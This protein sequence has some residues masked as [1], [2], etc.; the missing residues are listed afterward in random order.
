MIS[1]RFHQ[2]SGL[3]DNCEFDR[4]EKK[5]TLMDLRGFWEMIYYQVEDVD[6]KFEAL[7]KQKQ[8]NWIHL[9]TITPA[10][11]ST[12]NRKRSS[13]SQVTSKATASSGL[14]ALIAAKRK[15]VSK[16]DTSDIVVQESEETSE[17]PCSP[18]K[19]FDGGFFKISSPQLTQDSPSRLTRSAGLTTQCLTTIIAILNCFQDVSGQCGGPRC[20]R[21]PRGCLD[22]SPP[23]CLNSQGGLS[24]SGELYIGK[25]SLLFQHT[26]LIAETNV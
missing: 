16:D 22:W 1:E 7:K 8:S 18:E 20:P 13:K 23:S 4:G 25:L 21:V 17:G 12:T 11:V 10:L 26:Q 14:K 19:T 5:T 9:K 24:T 3:V 15:K 2:F 6:Q